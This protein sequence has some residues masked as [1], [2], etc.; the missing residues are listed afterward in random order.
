MRKHS[1]ALPPISLSKVLKIRDCFHCRDAMLRVSC[2][3]S[4]RN[5]D[6]RH[7]VSTKTD[8]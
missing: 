3:G 6:A 7:R 4:P 1:K 2:S 8:R 5:R